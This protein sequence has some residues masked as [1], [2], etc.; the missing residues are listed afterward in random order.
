MKLVTRKAQVLLLV[1]I[2][3]ELGCQ[4]KNTV[5]LAGG[6]ASITFVNAIPTSMPIIPVINTSAPVLYFREAQSIGYGSFS[7]YSALGGMDTIYIVQRNSDTLNINP[8]SPTLMYYSLLSLKAGSMHTLFL[9]GSDTTSPDYLFTTDTIPNYA[10]TDSI[11]G[12]R[13]VNLS[14]GSNPISIN[15]EGSQNGSEEVALPYKGITAFKQYVNNSSTQDY[16]F[17]FRD[18][19]TGDS[20]TQFDFFQSGSGN[21]GYGLIDPN[22]G[23]LLTFKNVTIALY[24]SEA[25][26]SNFPLNTLLIDNY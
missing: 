25:T 5:T 9:T 4:K 26:M 11:M 24:G 22:T 1:V 21:Y 8:K 20:L 13:F 7:E 16:L 2:V 12:I 17:V 18:A 15:L 23:N 14:T 10:P 6:P 19:A 3:I